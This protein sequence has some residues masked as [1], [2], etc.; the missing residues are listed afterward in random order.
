M[1]F[2]TRFWGGK[3]LLTL[4][5]EKITFLSSDIFL[6]FKVQRYEEFNIILL[7]CSPKN[8]IRKGA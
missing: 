8:L 6:K 3:V 5:I 4:T 1:L 2:K 7:N